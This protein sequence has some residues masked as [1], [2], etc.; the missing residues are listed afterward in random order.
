MENKLSSF[1]ESDVLHDLKHYLPAQ[2]PLKDFIHHNT[3]HAFQHQSF[4]TALSK[5]SK[6]FGYKVSLSLKE[7]RDLYRSGRITDQAINLAL[8]RKN[9]TKD[10]K[11]WQVRMLEKR[12]NMSCDPRVGTLRAGWEKYFHLDL[13]VLVHPILFRIICSYLDQGI[14]IWNFPVTDKGLLN[15]IRELEKNAFSSFFTSKRAKDL[16]NSRCKIS[17]LLH[18]IVGDES[19]YEHY[20]YDQQFAHQGWSGMVATIEEQPETLMD[21]KRISLKDLIILELLLE[22]DALDQKFGYVWAPLGHLI[23]VPLE[24][25]FAPTPSTEYDVVLNLWQEAFEW[26]YY[27][28]VL[29][30]INQDRP[31]RKTAAIP[32][33]Q[34]IV[35]IDD[36]EISLRDYME[37][38]DPN[39]Q[40]FATPGFF[41]VE[42]FFQPEHGRAYTK[43]CPA[44]VTPKYLIKEVET[45]SGR[46]KDVHLA[47]QS[48]SLLT[49]WVMAPTIGFWSAIR[50]F[51]SI[52]KPSASPATASSFNHMDNQSRLSIRR[53]SE[54]PD[55]N[56]LQV[57]FTTIEMAQRVR[58]MLRSIGLTQNFGK[59]VYIMG[60]GAS[61]ANN[62]HYAAY[63]C[64][65]CCGRPGSV[66]ARVFAAMANDPEVRQL[67]NEEGL[68]IPSS[69]WFIGALHD[70]TRDEAEYFDESQIPET[71]RAQHVENKKNIYTALLLNSKERS[72]RFELIDHSASPKKIH[73]KILRRSVSLFEPRPELNHATNALCI[74]GS[75]ELTSGIFLDRRAFANSYDYRTDPEGKMLADIMRPLGPVCGGINLEYYFSRVD[76]QKLGAGSK[77]PH[78]VMG[79]FGVANGFDGDLRPGLPNQMIEL[80]E[81]MRL[82]IIVEHEPSVVLA[83]IQ[84]AD[85]M[86][87]WYINEWIHLVVLQPSTH[88]YF[89]FKKGAFEPYETLGNKVEQVNDMN[90]ILET[91]R[92]NLPVYIMNV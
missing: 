7:Y 29:A 15:S 63:N 23:T 1:N 70:T 53:T 41:G 67:L 73:H 59:L 25:L 35:C 26:N 76:N 49:G 22:I 21:R 8:D 79:L 82:M 31:H 77:L 64:G 9:F 54:F 2:A 10:K 12:Y 72:R 43:Q 5:A 62:P 91:S 36:R 60:H 16:L 27:D 38:T 30:A 69:T 90:S 14:S 75:R 78:N 17:D 80:H 42:F 92:E 19:L 89:V 48:H 51:I 68:V 13:D 66:N 88:R 85:A 57:G 20:L 33:F 83:T 44:P 37:K 3:L 50:L 34:A 46:K 84:S 55:E 18:I 47:K 28:N 24:P 52:F 40:T 81:P 45:N 11:D 86:Y 87:E 58:N 56:G 6:V 39:C 32:S 65:A 74:V 4:F 71:L 61:S